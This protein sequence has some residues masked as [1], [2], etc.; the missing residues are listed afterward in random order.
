MGEVVPLSAAGRD[1]DDPLRALVICK[2]ALL[3]RA[4]ADDQFSDAEYRIYA[5]ALDYTHRELVRI[6]WHAV[7]FRL[8]TGPRCWRQRPTDGAACAD[9]IRYPG[10]SASR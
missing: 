7:A 3:S 4:R 2:S 9:Q 8:Q 10:I 5:A 6:F 1:Q